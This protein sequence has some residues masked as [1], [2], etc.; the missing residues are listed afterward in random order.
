MKSCFLGT[1][2]VGFVALD[3]MAGAAL[4]QGK[5]DCGEAYKA[6]LDKITMP[7]RLGTYRTPRRSSKDWTRANI[8][9]TCPQCPLPAASG[10]A[11]HVGLCVGFRMPA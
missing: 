5:I 8:R 3:L 9:D 7:V 6:F 1:I 10:R 2:L 11:E 4:A